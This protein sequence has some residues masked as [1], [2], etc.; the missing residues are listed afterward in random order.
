[1][2]VP[3]D[4]RGADSGVVPARYPRP[5]PE[6]TG[7]PRARLPAVVCP[8]H[9]HPEVGGQMGRCRECDRDSDRGEYQED[10]KRYGD[11]PQPAVVTIYGE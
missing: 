3:A 7:H 6:F 4:D 8:C 10:G 2:T 9:A 5:G 11:S 1:V